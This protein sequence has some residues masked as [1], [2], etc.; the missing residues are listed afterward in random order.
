M[1]SIVLTRAF[2]LPPIYIYTCIRFSSR[3]WTYTSRA[4][5]KT[6]YFYTLSFIRL[7]QWRQKERLSRQVQRDSVTIYR[8]AIEFEK[9]MNGRDSFAPL[10]ARGLIIAGPA[11]EFQFFAALSIAFS[12]YMHKRTLICCLF[13]LTL[14]IWV[15]KCGSQKLFLVK[16]KEKLFSVRIWLVSMLQRNIGSEKLR[17]IITRVNIIQK[18]FHTKSLLVTF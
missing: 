11:I 1:T 7:S 16:K 13:V 8:R 6:V 9:R 4:S 12:R 3:Q 2:Q 17:F 14:V 5:G 18:Y 15:Y 10:R